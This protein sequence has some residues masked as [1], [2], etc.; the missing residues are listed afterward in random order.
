MRASDSSVGGAA[1]Q[2][3]TTRQA[4]VMVSAD[5]IVSF[6]WFQLATSAAKMPACPNRQVLHFATHIPAFASVGQG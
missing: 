6:R 3:H 1:G 5:V 2:C 4:V